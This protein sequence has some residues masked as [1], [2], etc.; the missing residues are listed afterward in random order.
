LS[1]EV[2]EFIGI[3]TKDGKSIL[4][5]ELPED[6][7]L[8]YHLAA[9]ASVEDSWKDPVRNMENLLTAVRLSQ[10]YPNTKIV[11]ASTCAIDDPVTPYG[12]SKKCAHDYLKRFHPNSVILVFPNIFGGPRSVVDIFKRVEKINVHDPHVV[13]DYVH[14]DDIVKGLVLAKDWE[15]GEYSLGS[16]KGTSTLELAQSTGKEYEI[17]APRSGGKE[18]KESIVP[19]T[20]PGWIPT[21][22]VFEYIN[23][24]D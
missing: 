12:F 4:T 18:P 9:H 6:V 16:G 13:R 19:N 21:V 10:V 1:K 7:D 2:G 11:Y 14:V 15:P 20:T 5:C 24:H 22:D 23:R 8:I 17:T 3:D